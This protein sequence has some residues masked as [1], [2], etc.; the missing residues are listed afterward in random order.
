MDNS[1]NKS[2]FREEMARLLVVLILSILSLGG[3]VAEGNRSNYCMDKSVDYFPYIM[4]HHI[5]LASDWF[6]VF[7]SCL[8]CRT[9]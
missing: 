5:L 7:P 4:K 3:A 2:L 1:Y 8:Y 6:R 9:D